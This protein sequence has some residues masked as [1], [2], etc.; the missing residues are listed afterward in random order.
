MTAGQ[1]LVAWQKSGSSQFLLTW[2]RDPT[3]ETISV[4]SKQTEIKASTVN[5][6]DILSIEGVKLKMKTNESM[7]VNI[8]SNP[9]NP[10]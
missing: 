1:T 3:S 10:Y 9:K 2:P 6:S 4:S 7:N 8:K 5:F